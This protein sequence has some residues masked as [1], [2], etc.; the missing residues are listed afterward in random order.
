MSWKPAKESKLYTGN[1]FGKWLKIQ[2]VKKDVTQRTLA[3]TLEVTEGCVS[4]WISG[5]S[6]PAR[7]LIMPLADFLEVTGDEILKRLIGK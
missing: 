7:R 6:V 5:Y 1:L 3:E 2:L 4:Q